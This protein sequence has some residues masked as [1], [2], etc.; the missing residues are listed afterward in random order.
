[1]RLGD[2]LAAMRELEQFDAQLVLLDIGLP[3]LDGYA[4]ADLIRQRCGTAAPYLVALSGYA[5]RHGPEGGGFDA[6]L[7]E[8]AG[9]RAAR[10]DSRATAGFSAAVCCRADRGCPA[11]AAVR[12]SASGTRRKS[13]STERATDN[14]SQ[15][16]YAVLHMKPAPM[17]SELVGRE[18]AVPGAVRLSIHLMSEERHL[19]VMHF[20]SRLV[21]SWNR[22]P[23]AQ[24]HEVGGLFP[25]GNDM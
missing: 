1:M 25:C 14:S 7:S 4:T 10:R 15:P 24:T 3:G 18:L 2:G 13:S 17:I 6:Y 23:S 8:A 19:V 9:A 20:D 16:A 21:I 22:S 12:R 5:S 11:I